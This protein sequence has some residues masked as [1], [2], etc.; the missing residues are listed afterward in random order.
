MPVH[1]S[2]ICLQRCCRT[3]LEKLYPAGVPPTAM[4]RYHREMRLLERAKKSVID[5]FLLFKELS[6]AAQKLFS[7]IYVSSPV[8]GTMLIYLLGDH[9]LNPLPAHYYCTACGYY[10]EP[11]GV[12]Q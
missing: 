9:D 10:T 2:F 11:R 12:A 6:D 8:Q 3:A 5:E 1:N 4:W 7:K